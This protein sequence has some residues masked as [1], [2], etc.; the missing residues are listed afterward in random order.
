MS[1]KAGCQLMDKI[2]KKLISSLLPKDGCL[3]YFENFYSDEDAIQLFDILKQETNWL[4]QKIKI[5]GKEVDQPRLTAWYSDPNTYYTYSGLTLKPTPW[6]KTLVK[7]KKNLESYTKR[8]FNGVLLNYYRDQNDYMG[9]H[10]DNEKELGLNPFIASLSF[11]Q[12][13]KFQLK[14]RKDKEQPIINL[15][16]KSGSLLLMSDE[17]QS[18]WLHRIA[19]TK[20]PMGPRINLTFRNILTT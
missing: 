12:E 20:K 15:D 3:E 19:P 6:T 7:I 1:C 14:H 18:N 9:W 8:P 17:I 5:F 4:S 11:G 2:K 16:L 13:R 10:S